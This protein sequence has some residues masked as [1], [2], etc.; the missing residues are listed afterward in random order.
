MFWQKKLFDSNFVS[1]TLLDRFWILKT[2]KKKP[3]NLPKCSQGT[4]KTLQNRSK[5]GVAPPKMAPKASQDAP[6]ASQDALTHLQERPRRFQ[7]ASRPS[8]DTP[9]ILHT[10]IFGGLVKL[11]YSKL[12]PFSENAKPSLNPKLQSPEENLLMSM[13]SSPRMRRSPRSG[14]NARGSTPQRGKS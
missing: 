3:K 7:A 12:W 6:T 1:G 10:S 14:L 9:K 5:I 2:S 13:G 11:S 4:S 8:Q